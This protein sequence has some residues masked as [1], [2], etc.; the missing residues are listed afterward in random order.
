MS[1]KLHQVYV[2]LDSHQYNRAIKLC[3]ALPK[4][5]I[6][7][8][9]LL[10]HAYAKSS[11]RYDALRTIQSILG[12][13]AFPEVQ[14]ELKYSLE[15]EESSVNA[16]APILGPIS[17]K[18]ANKKG[19]KKHSTAAVP[20]VAVSAPSAKQSDFDLIDRLDH[21][22]VLP[23]NWEIVPAATDQT[24]TDHTV[25]ATLSMT[26]LNQLNLPLTAYQLY[27]WA[28]KK[29][30]DEVLVSRAF[31]NGLAVLMAPQYQDIAPLVLANLQ[32]LALQLSRIQQR[33][34]GVTP[35]IAWAAQA[36]LWQLEAIE[37]SN[38]RSAD[39][40][41]LARAAMLPRLAESM[42]SKCVAEDSK[43]QR[44]EE[45]LLYMRALARQQKWE[46]S[47]DAIDNRLEISKNS[48]KAAPSRETLLY[49]KTKILEKLERYTD[50]ATILAEHLLTL[51]PDQ[52]DYWKAHIRCSLKMAENSAETVLLSEILAANV[53]K[54][55]EMDRRHPLRGPHLVAVDVSARRLELR[56][57]NT[58]VI[59]VIHKIIAYG[60]IFCARVACT[61]SDLRPYL[62][63]VLKVATSEEAQMLLLWLSGIRLKV[64]D[65]NCEF[66]ERGRQLRLLTFAT[67][68]TYKI[69]ALHG[70][71]E[72][73][74]LM[75]WKDLLCA[76]KE[77]KSSEPTDQAQKESRQSD[78][79]VL[80]AIQQLLRNTP[81]QDDLL[82]SATIL[83]SAMKHS[84]YNA[85]LKIS[86]IFTYSKL[87]A[88]AR[89][90]V[91]FG[92]LFVKHIQYESCSYLILPL[93]RSG[94]FYRETLTVCQEILRLQTATSREAVDFA[95]RAIENGTV[96]KADEFIAFQRGRM[97]QSLSTLEAKGLILD[98]AP[99]FQLEN[100]QAASLGAYHGIVGTEA[101]IERSR[102]IISEGHNP[103][104]A[105]SLLHVHGSI[106]DNLP[107]FCENRDL[108]ILSHDIL[109]EQRF[110]SPEKILSDSIRRGHHHNLLIRAALCVDAIK[111]PKRGKPTSP[112]NVLLKL[113]SSLLLSAKSA[114]DDCSTSLQSIGYQHLLHSMVTMCKTIA[115]IGVGDVN[116][117]NE[118]NSLEEREM[119]A[120]ELISHARESMIRG[121]KEMSIATRSTSEVSMLL[122]DYVV[123]LFA[124]S[125]MCAKLLILFGWGHRKEKTKHCAGAFSEFYLAFASLVQD[126]V[127]CLNNQPTDIA[128]STSYWSGV[129]PDLIDDEILNETVLLVTRGRE[130]TKRRIRGILDEVKGCLDDFTMDY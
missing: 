100:S 116:G 113:R 98:C 115:F 129:I 23:E 83:E 38:S 93:L 44:A 66:K 37:S 91:L 17:S 77:F 51:S 57:S 58:G 47:L 122:S 87:D 20:P 130:E 41:Q 84:P 82:L 50:A 94:G 92:D 70:N 61:F 107:M 69:L 52:W 63:Q 24:P 79:L 39:P 21:P 101:D 106:S 109:V 34:Y 62:D 49:K 96:S 68:M 4:T 78:E 14:L 103:R 43:G 97:N 104:A 121:Q 35:A 26:M 73:E 102:K 125:R 2:A 65:L 124:L 119:K 46:E 5:N 40:Q 48:E 25:L 36:A 80:L 76:W 28:I 27:C 6:L 85:Y 9:A 90:W 33:S 89:A 120:A 11:Q 71:L 126:M 8:Q 110:D 3:L 108:S 1:S 86:A 30:E 19:K 53:I 111:S 88:T 99:M 45:F 67:Q 95:G 105:F 15:T 128:L 114:I 60:D 16:T 72:T 56:P 32:L 31:T 117:D 22:P 127:S 112:S 13:D 123:S 7:G 59:E 54:T 29:F 18:K 55:M 75:H 118:G 10:A 81:S 12:T 74:F 42:A 64:R